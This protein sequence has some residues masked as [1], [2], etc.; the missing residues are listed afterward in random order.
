M[1]KWYK[2]SSEEISKELNLANEHDPLIIPS[3][4][5]YK[6]LTEELNAR[7]IWVPGVNINDGIVCDYA[8][9]NRMLHFD[10]DFEKDILTAAK[11]I[12]EHYQ[13]YSNHTEA[14][15]NRSGFYP[16]RLWS[17]CEPCKSGRVFLSDYYGIRN[18][19]NDLCGTRDCG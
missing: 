16:S 1:N 8:E 11:N 19:W 14:V 15:L 6:R 12:A 7:Y 18:Y 9:K 4:V 17:L 2:K 5:L 10:H 3:V 13:G